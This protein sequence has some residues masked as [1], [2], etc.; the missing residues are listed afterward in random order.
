M[1]RCDGC[2][3]DT[4]ALA[5]C[6]EAMVCRSCYRGGLARACPLCGRR[7]VLDDGP[8]EVELECQV[9]ELRRRASLI[10]EACEE[11][12]EANHERTED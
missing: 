9:C 4:R 11:E 3:L 2:G 5:R 1:A 12:M 6:G 10:L 8:V 7:E